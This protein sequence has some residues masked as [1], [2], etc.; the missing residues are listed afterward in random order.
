MSDRT[1]APSEARPATAADG[2]AIAAILAANDE[3]LQGSAASG[4]PYLDHL[5][6]R[7]RVV[8]AELDGVLAGFAAAIAVGPLTHISDLFVDP[9]RQSRGLGRR[10][11]DALTDEGVGRPWTTFSSGD[12]RAVALYV[13]AGLRPWWP[14]LYLITESGPG[15]QG[16]AGVVVDPVTSTAASEADHRL[17]GI[18]RSND[19]R[20]WGALPGGRGIIVRSDAGSVIAAGIASSLARS[21]GTWL[22]H[23]AIDPATSDEVAA[24]AVMA[25]MQAVRGESR[26][27]LSIP[28]PHPALP[29]LLASGY[30]IF[31]RDTFCA[32]D[33]GVINPGRVIP[34]ASFL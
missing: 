31:E 22:R 3:P 15:R 25:A 23:L 1:A 32:T 2:P 33:P 11:I 30:R 17:S 16:S 20:Y 4:W 7:G 10:L 34:D 5:L 8:V 29:I 27:G 28:G 14:N 9:T 18:D 6:E 24:A 21:E 26:G 12:P 13:G 19:Y